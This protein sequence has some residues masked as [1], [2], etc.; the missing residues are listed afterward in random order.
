MLAQWA[1]DPLVLPYL[2]HLLIGIA[3]VIAACRAG[4]EIRRDR[5]GRVPD[6]P[7]LCQAGTTGTRT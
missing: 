4:N 3:V 7:V 1:P 6:P 2:P 5:V